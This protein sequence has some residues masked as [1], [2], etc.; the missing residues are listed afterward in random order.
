MTRTL[1]L[2]DICD[3]KYYLSFEY[4]PWCSWRDWHK[5]WINPTY[6]GTIAGIVWQLGRIIVLGHVRS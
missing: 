4:K 1:S 5:P 3:S 2:G 6:N